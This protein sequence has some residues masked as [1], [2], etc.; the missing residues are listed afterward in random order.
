MKEQTISQTKLI[1]LFLRSYFRFNYQLLWSEQDQPA[2]AAFHNHFTAENV[3]DRTQNITSIRD[4]SI[5]LLMFYHLQEP[6]LIIHEIQLEPYM[7]LHHFFLFLNTLIEQFNQKIIIIITNKL[8]VIFMIHLITPFFHRLI[9][10]F[11]Q[12]LF[13][14]F[15]NLT[16][17]LI[18]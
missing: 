16:I 18:Q 5:F 13:N 7:I 11:N 12:L 14:L 17:I 2:F 6:F 8:L 15:L 10:I 1:T 9:Q 4:I 3:Q